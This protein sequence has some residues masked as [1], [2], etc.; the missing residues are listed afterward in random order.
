[1]TG[2]LTQLVARGL[3]QTDVAR[4]RPV[5]RFEPLGP[6]D[7]ALPSPA[8]PEA[9][10][11]VSTADEV[12]TPDAPRPTPRRAQR[13]LPGRPP[14]GDDA[15]DEP[16]RRAPPAPTVSLAASA[17]PAPAPSAPPPTPP[18]PTV[19]VLVR[20]AAASDADAAP[21]PMAAIPSPARI[22][23]Q[24]MPPPP[25][26]VVVPPAGPAPPIPHTTVERILVQPE[27]HPLAERPAPPSSAA[28]LPPPAPS[29]PTVHVTIGRLEVRATPPPAPA[30]APRPAEPSPPVKLD[31]YLRRRGGRE[32]P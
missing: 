28:S 30:R 3:G 27:I 32:T 17:P 31:D 29:A 10:E 12:M 1:M 20:D 15:I 8:V 23:G 16:P 9:S 7:A 5:S 19:S 18:T 24:I 13:S 14:F 2:F 26:P 4:P 6:A 22:E 25:A 21:T 11:A